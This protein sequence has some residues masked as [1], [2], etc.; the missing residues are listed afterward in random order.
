MEGVPVK[1]ASQVDRLRDWFE[2]Q[3]RSWWTVLR[4]WFLAPV[5]VV[6]V[7]YLFGSVL[8]SLPTLVGAIVFVWLALATIGT[9]ISGVVLIVL[10]TEI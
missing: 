10:R 6:T 5:A 2:W 1:A 9:V 3:A 8:R 7:W 4:Y